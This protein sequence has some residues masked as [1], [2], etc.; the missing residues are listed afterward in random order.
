M[1]PKAV[2]HARHAISCLLFII[3]ILLEAILSRRG[4]ELAPDGSEVVSVAIGYHSDF[5]GSY[6]LKAEGGYLHST[7]L[8]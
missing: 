7:A 2:L 4:G 3:V 5:V 6:L 1:D 8:R